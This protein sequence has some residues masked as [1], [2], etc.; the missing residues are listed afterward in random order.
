MAVTGKRTYSSTENGIWP[1]LLKDVGHSG[2]AG[3]AEHSTGDD[4]SRW[5]H[6]KGTLRSVI[7]PGEKAKDRRNRRD[8]ESVTRH[9]HIGF[10]RIRTLR[11]VIRPGEKAKDRRNRRD[12]ES[13]TRHFHIG[14]FRIRLIIISFLMR[15]LNSLNSTQALFAL[16]CTEISL[17]ST[18]QSAWKRFAKFYRFL[19]D[20]NDPIPLGLVFC[21]PIHS[22]CGNSEAYNFSATFTL[23]R[24]QVDKLPD[25][26][27]HSKRCFAYHGIEQQPSSSK[28]AKKKESK[29][30]SFIDRYDF[31]CRRSER[32][33]Y[34]RRCPNKV[35]LIVERF[36]NEK[37]LD[38]LERTLFIV[39]G[40]MTAGQ[41]QN[42]INEQFD[43]GRV[44]VQT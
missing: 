16:H 2:V 22:L 34:A 18:R 17:V 8:P 15:F 4:R 32:E 5:G 31:C 28:G 29:R 44:R 25:E 42:V 20:Q 36:K 39:P 6:V 3:V 37:V 12:P 7:R 21:Y 11:S 19:N 38:D 1:D 14:F 30:T 24:E 26:K 33:Y 35:A 43:D 10:F 9:F 27:T 23:K 13:V 41:L 40:A